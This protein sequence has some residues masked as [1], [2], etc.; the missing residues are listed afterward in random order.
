MKY[1]C[2]KCL[3]IHNSWVIQIYPQGPNPLNSKS[4]VNSEE[5]SC[6]SASRK[7]L[8]EVYKCAGNKAGH[9][10]TATKWIQHS[11]G[12]PSPGWE[13][14]N[15][16]TLEGRELPSRPRPMYLFTGF[17]SVSFKTTGK[18]GQACSRGSTGPGSGHST[19]TGVALPQ[20]EWICDLEKPNGSV[21]TDCAHL[22]YY[23]KTTALSQQNLTFTE[24]I[25]RYFPFNDRHGIKR[26]ISNSVRSKPN[27]PPSSDLP[28]SIITLHHSAT[29]ARNLGGPSFV[30]SP[31]YFT[32]LYVLS[33]LPSNTL[34]LILHLL[35][36][37]N[38]VA[39]ASENSC[40]SLNPQYI[41][42]SHANIC[43]SLLKR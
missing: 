22:I 14:G 13:A 37:L 23:A 41:G 4:W 6:N 43:S 33:T 34:Q 1:T 25:F 30:A 24:Y 32:A 8:P 28:S 35:L 26:T 3:D 27:S 2:F 16:P 20:S 39:P 11:C 5:A 12:L 40:L 9:V 7:S 10:G 18:G 17:S 19:C 15:T 29:Q 31:M 42:C 21:H 38:C 36:G